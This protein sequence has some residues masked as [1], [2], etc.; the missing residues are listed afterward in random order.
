MR[1]P[2]IAAALV[3]AGVLL[4]APPLT[5]ERPASRETGDEPHEINRLGRDIVEYSSNRLPI[6][7]D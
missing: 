2:L 1:A 5:A 3:L 4:A 6:E 7:I